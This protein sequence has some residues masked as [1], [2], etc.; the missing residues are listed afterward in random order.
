VI[1]ALG[2]ESVP[3]VLGAV[4]FDTFLPGSRHHVTA[5]SIHFVRRLVE[6]VCNHLSGT[7][8]RGTLKAP[9]SQLVTPISTKLQRP[10]G[11]D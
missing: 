8:I 3:V 2:K 1:A 4:W 10:D 11:C 9:K 7:I 6:Y 5:L